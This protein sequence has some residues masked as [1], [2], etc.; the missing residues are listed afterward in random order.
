MGS[1]PNKSCD[2]CTSGLATGQY[3]VRQEILQREVKQMLVVYIVAILAGTLIA[4]TG[5][6][7]LQPKPQEVKQMCSIAPADDIQ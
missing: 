4:C 3:I 5:L 7:L 1:I 6:L 2:V